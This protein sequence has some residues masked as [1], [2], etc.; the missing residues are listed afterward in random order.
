[1]ATTFL[2]LP[3]QLRSRFN[4]LAFKDTAITLTFKVRQKHHLRAYYP[5]FGESHNTVSSANKCLEPVPDAFL[6]DDSCLTER[7][8][9][10]SSVIS[11]LHVSRQVHADINSSIYSHILLRIKTSVDLVSDR[12]SA[13]CFSSVINN[14]ILCDPLR[15]AGT[16]SAPSVLMD[17][18][19]SLLH[20]SSPLLDGLHTL[21]EYDNWVHGVYSSPAAQLA[22]MHHWDKEVIVEYLEQWTKYRLP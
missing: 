22:A 18:W 12:P 10:Q 1:M 11:L 14:P 4:D 20:S 9:P 16:I 13:G 15:R 5:S 8:A 21:I 17:A 2:S 3:P 6:P 7:L 19:V